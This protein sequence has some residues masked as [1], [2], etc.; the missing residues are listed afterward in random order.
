MRTIS[1]SLPEGL[2]SYV[3]ELVR[4]GRWPSLDEC[5]SDALTEFADRRRHPKITDEELRASLR[6]AMEQ[7]ERGEY[8]DGEEFMDEMIRDLESK[9]ATHE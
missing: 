8:V 9:S 4:G 3:E 7:I 5:V 1:V 2:L 6:E